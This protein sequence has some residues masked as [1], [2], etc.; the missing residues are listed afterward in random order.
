[1]WIFHSLRVTGGIREDSYQRF[2]CTACKANHITSDTGWSRVWVIQQ[3]PGPV[4]AV[5]VH[6]PRR[7]VIELLR[8][9]S[10]FPFLTKIPYGMVSGTQQ[11]SRF[12]PVP[13]HK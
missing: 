6:Q 10:R 9:Y 8:P 11:D 5:P 7:A 3:H 2:T 12:L 13:A 1:H 4:G